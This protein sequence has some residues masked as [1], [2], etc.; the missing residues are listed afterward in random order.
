MTGIT[1]FLV[2]KDPEVDR[3]GDMAMFS[4]VYSLAQKLGPT[5][6]IALGSTPGRRDGNLVIE[7]TKPSALRLAASAAMNRRSLVH[8]RFDLPALR[9]AVAASDAD[10]FVADHTYMAEPVFTGGDRRPVYINTV[11][12]E[13]LVWGAS[14]GTLGKVQRA[15]ILRDEVR[16]ARRAVA[17]ATYDADE[18]ETLAAAGVTRTRWLDVTLPPAPRIERDLSRPRVAFVGDRQWSPNEEGARLLLEW[19]PAIR[20]GIPD[21][22]LLLI[23]RSAGP[24]PEVEGV[25]ELGFV[26]D[27]DATLAGC[28]GILASIATGGGVR[29]KILDAISRGMPVVGTPAAVG[30]LDRIFDIPVEPTREAFIARARRLLTDPD[31]ARTLGEQIYEQN[32]E[33]WRQE[34]PHRAVQEW[35]AP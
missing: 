24:L 22:E 13:S 4:L 17:V 35:L 14:R 28:R 18:A 6:Y 7:K 20:E 1:E 27:L 32:V 19:W 26:D 21:A 16:T 29:V 30:S 31:Y 10:R 15:A 8:E 3:T 23:G 2:A 5:R 9:E 12:S 11:V 34:R 33:H 25:V